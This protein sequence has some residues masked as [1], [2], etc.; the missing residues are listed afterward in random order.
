MNKKQIKYKKKLHNK[1]AVLWLTGLPSSGKSTIADRLFEI[2]SKG[3]LKVQRLDG[4]IFR[5]YFGNN[6]GFNKADRDFNI[7][8]AAFISSIL[9]KHK[10]LVI[11]SFITPYSHQRDIVRNISGSFIEIFINASLDTCIKR[12]AKGLYKKAIAGEIRNFTGISDPYEIPENPHLTIN[13]EE[14][15]IEESVDKIIKYLL[16]NKHIY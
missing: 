5:N 15:N 14:L 2:L 9:E 13:T 3:G 8:T 7:K 10:I 16:D 4:D 12:D 6:L 11:A 1:K